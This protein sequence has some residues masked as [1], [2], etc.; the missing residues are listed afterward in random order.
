VT[1]CGG[2][3]LGGANPA[4]PP[5]L[6]EW[7]WSD[8]NVASQFD[9]APFDST[10]G[11]VS[12]TFPRPPYQAAT[13]VLPISKNDGKVRRGVPDIAGM[14]ATQGF[15][16]NGAGPGGFIGTSAVS[17]LYAGLVAIINAFLGRNVGFLNPTLY[18]YGPQICNDITVG[19]NDSG[20][21][22]NSPF[23]TTDIG[24]DACTGWGSI[25]G[26]RLLAAVAPAPIIVTAFPDSGVFMDTCLDSFVDEIL[27]IDNSGFSTLLIWNIMS[28]LADFEVPGVASY[29][30][31]V[32]PGGSINVVIRFKPT[33]VGFRAGTITI[34]SNDLFNPRSI[35]VS[36]TGVAPGDRRQRQFW[37]CVP[38]LVQG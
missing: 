9:V 11:G 15:F 33:V 14:V 29:P 13:G 38:W 24:W 27:T 1:A 26:M 21:T 19:N 20:N 7:A 10:G 32:S 34:F 3:I 8:A 17:P 31:A 28:S 30:I 23:Y 16:V 22:P 35:S 25:N 2:T 5:L 4:P 18:T 36:G 37:R 12:D 6:D